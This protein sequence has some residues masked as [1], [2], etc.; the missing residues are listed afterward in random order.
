MSL[1]P[2]VEKHSSKQ[3]LLAIAVLC[4]QKLLDRIV[5]VPV[6]L[7]MLRNKASF[8]TPIAA[9]ITDLGALACPRAKHARA[10]RCVHVQHNRV[11]RGCQIIPHRDEC[12]VILACWAQWTSMRRSMRSPS[13]SSTCSAG[14][15][16]IAG[17]ATRTRWQNPAIRTSAS[18]ASRC[19][20]SVRCTVGLSARASRHRHVSHQLPVV[21]R[22]LHSKGPQ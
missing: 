14:S 19:T 20:K 15:A 21:L 7:A 8:H 1:C 17:R 13:S 10:W 22:S 6:D 18:R 11:V 3:P 2:L 9:A 5:E 4:W 12:E 16:G